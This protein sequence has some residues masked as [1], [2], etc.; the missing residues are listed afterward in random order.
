[1]F[2]LPTK[3]ANIKNGRRGKDY[4]TRIRDV[5][6]RV[7]QRRNDAET[8]IAD[9]YQDEM[10]AHASD[11]F[12]GETNATS[13]SSPPARRLRPVRNATRI[14]LSWKEG[15][16]AFPRT[17]SRVGE[18]YQAVDLPSSDTFEKEQQARDGTV[19]DGMHQGEETRI[20]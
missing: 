12:V 17:S 15:G 10:N 8:K 16:S 1:M 3:D 14:D 4:Y 11:E 20:L 13:E 6:D 18:E 19:S 2:F 5:I 9:A 7:L